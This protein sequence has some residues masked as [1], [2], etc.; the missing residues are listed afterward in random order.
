MPYVVFWAMA[1]TRPERGS[2]ETSASLRPEASP[3]GIVFVSEEKAAFCIVGSIV[4][5]IVM[6]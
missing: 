4:V 5:R 3:T 6:P 2:R 1:R